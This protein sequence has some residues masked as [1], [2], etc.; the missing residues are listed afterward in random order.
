MQYA[1]MQ[2]HLY[3]PSI[4]YVYPCR[5]VLHTPYKHFARDEW[6]DL[7][8]ENVHLFPLEMIG[9]RMK[10]AP[11]QAHLY[12]PSIKYV[13]P[14][15]GVLHTPY[16]HPARD[17]WIDPESENVH[18]FP[19]ETIEGRMQY[20]PTQV[21]L[22]HPSIQYAYPCRGVMLTPH[23]HPTRNEWIDPESENVH[24]FP[25]E[26]IEGRMQYAPT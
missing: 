7:K 25:L 9:W 16:K 22:H 20:A 3:H 17:E 15:R 19:L 26:T 2:A 11:T 6:I 8:S 10:N 1:P 12:H 14:C 13:Y 4:Q 21:H 24:P 23:Y 5:G 18:P